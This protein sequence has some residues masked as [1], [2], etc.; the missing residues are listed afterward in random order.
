MISMNTPV[1]LRVA[2]NWA[3]TTESCGDSSDGCTRD[4]TFQSLTS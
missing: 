2:V 1:G 3:S 4:A